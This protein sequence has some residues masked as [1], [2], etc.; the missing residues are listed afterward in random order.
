MWATTLERLMERLHPFIEQLH[1][2][3]E[4]LDR[5]IERLHPFIEQL[6]RPLELLDPSPEQPR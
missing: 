3:L 5:S 1:R 2:P 6:H 4:L